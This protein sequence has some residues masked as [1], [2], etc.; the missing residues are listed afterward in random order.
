LIEIHNKSTYQRIY[1]SFSNTFIESFC[2]FRGNGHTTSESLTAAK[3]S[4]QTQLV[5]LL[6]K[7]QLNPD[8]ILKSVEAYVNLKDDTELI[9]KAIEYFQSMK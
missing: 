4:V 9:H 1:Q 7:K 3:I 6:A 5:D 2:S 8:T